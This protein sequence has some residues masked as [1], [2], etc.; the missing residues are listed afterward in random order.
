MNVNKSTKKSNLIMH[1]VLSYVVVR[2]FKTFDSLLILLLFFS[3]VVHM[4]QSSRFWVQQTLERK[5]FLNHSKEDLACSKLLPQLSTVISFII[6]L[7]VSPIK[8]SGIKLSRN[9]YKRKKEQHGLK[10]AG[11]MHHRHW[12]VNL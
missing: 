11:F 1:C 10:G 6:S 5:I 3:I 4:V 8:Y 9:F 12:K 2:A 7:Q